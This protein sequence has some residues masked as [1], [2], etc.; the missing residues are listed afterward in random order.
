MAEKS[1][2]NPRGAG[3][4]N[5]PQPH[6]VIYPPGI[7]GDMRLSYTRMKAQCKFRNEQ[8][9]LSWD[10]YQTIWKDN[11]HRRG[12]HIDS[13][14]LSRL[15]W[16]VP[17]HIDNCILLVREDHFKMMMYAREYDHIDFKR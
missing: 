12:R 7:I 11:W 10:D 9:Q 6:L 5:R 13:V 14:C 3:R 4:K 1:E 16:S 2:K 8:F 15:D 17:W